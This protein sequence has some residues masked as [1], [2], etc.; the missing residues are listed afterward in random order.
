M[1]IKIFKKGQASIEF[2]FAMIV[3]L[4]MAYAIIRLFDWSGRDLIER[5]QGHEQ[6]LFQ[7]DR[8]QR[9]YNIIPGEPV[10][11]SQLRQINPVLTP[12]TRFDGV[13]DGN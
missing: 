3:A 4:L 7:T 9:A 11:S 13:W 6:T 1:R 5:R 8:S 12:P 10:D 2:A